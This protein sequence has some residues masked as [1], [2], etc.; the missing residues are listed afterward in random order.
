[1]DKAIKIKGDVKNVA[2]YPWYFNENQCLL[3]LQGL[4]LLK[5]KL[6]KTINNQDIHENV[7]ECK[8]YAST[9]KLI[10]NIK[11]ERQ[12]FE[13]IEPMY[14]HIGPANALSKDTQNIVKISAMV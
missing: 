5:E 9:V 4:T 8:K 1:M 13:M 2:F 7:E 11:N 6:H 3:M 10:E 12:N 14:A